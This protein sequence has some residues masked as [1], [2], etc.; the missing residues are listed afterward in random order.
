MRGR[1]V[2]VG[3]GCDE[4]ELV[5]AVR[6]GDIPD[7]AR[8]GGGAQ[9]H[10]LLGWDLP[11]RP[12]HALCFQLLAVHGW[13]VPACAGGCVRV[14]VHAVPAGD[15]PDWIRVVGGSGLYAMQTSV[16]SDRVRYGR[17]GGLLIV[18]RRDLPDWGGYDQRARLH[19]MRWLAGWATVP[20]VH[21]ECAWRVLH[22][23]LLVVGHV[24]RAWT[25]LGSGCGM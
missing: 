8:Y 13:S 1:H 23:P 6:C 5:R 15:V 9:L 19:S 17:R 7:W 10:A 21:S 3:A 20:G 16:V 22:R 2:P 18:R 24:Q 11:V 14:A 25:L 4:C 12:R